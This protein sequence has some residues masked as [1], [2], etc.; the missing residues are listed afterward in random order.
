MTIIY[1]LTDA[2]IEE[3]FFGNK[4][5]SG[6]EENGIKSTLKM[7]SKEFSYSAVRV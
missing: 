5:D 6:N 4:D 2:K 3:M 1:T 7:I